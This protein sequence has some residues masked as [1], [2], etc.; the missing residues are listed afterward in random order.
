MS[1]K[2]TKN[3][4]IK[5]IDGYNYNTAIS[6]IENNDM[7]YVLMF[8]IVENN[9]RLS[10][11]F[12]FENLTIEDFIHKYSLYRDDKF[13]FYNVKDRRFIN[14]PG[15]IVDTV[16]ILE[17]YKH[18]ID[19]A[20]MDYEEKD[21]RRKYLKMLEHYSVS[22]YHNAVDVL[23]NFQKWKGLTIE[24]VIKDFKENRIFNSLFDFNVYLEKLS[25]IF[26][27]TKDLIYIKKCQ[28]QVNN[29]EHSDKD[30]E[31]YT[32]ELLNNSDI[33]SFNNKSRADIISAYNALKQYE[34]D[35]KYIVNNHRTYKSR[36]AL[37]Y[38]SGMTVVFWLP[39]V[40][41]F[42]YGLFNYGIDMAIGEGIGAVLLFSFTT[43]VTLPLSFAWSCL[44]KPKLIY[45]FTFSTPSKY[46][47]IYIKNMPQNYKHCAYDI[48]LER[49]NI[50]NEQLNKN[51]NAVLA[52]T[53]LSK[54]I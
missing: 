23:Q 15:Y 38:L 9:N 41:G 35:I 2:L 3:K 45:D 46:K 13:V 43:P 22:E 34:K 51:S 31:Q 49:Y 14:Q 54:Y 1:I 7:S 44:V 19:A 24:I 6:I 27:I 8:L 39:F 5:K 4:A 10:S 25:D 37:G 40:I 33:I 11:M 36:L 42:L 32:R 28:R 50:N 30:I 53:L 20:L 16:R 47:H 21:K 12:T 29:N 52:G 48:L 18:D 26:D 17:K